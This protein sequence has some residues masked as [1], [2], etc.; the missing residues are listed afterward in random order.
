MLTDNI[1]KLKS[2][3]APNTHTELRLQCNTSASVSLFCGNQVGNARNTASGV[4]A[5]VFKN[6]VWGFSS[7]ADTSEEAAKSVLSAATDNANF[8]DSRVKNA[9][10]TL[11]AAEE[12]EY[13]MYLNSITMYPPN[14]YFLTAVGWLLL[15]VLFLAAL[16]ALYIVIVT[17]VKKIRRKRRRQLNAQQRR[18]NA[19]MPN[20]ETSLDIQMG[21]RHRNM[22]GTTPRE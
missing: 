14:N 3:F 18:R 1:S 7:A 21:R 9:P 19:G 12:G 10:I 22:P 20:Y 2:R 11:P 13:A 8:L 6:G 5:R 4:S 17:I 15:V 16:L